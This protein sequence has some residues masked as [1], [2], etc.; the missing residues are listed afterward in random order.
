MRNI[1]TADP[2]TTL[3]RRGVGALVK[4]AVKKVNLE[5]HAIPYYF[6]SLSIYCTLTVKRMA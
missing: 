6:Q 4:M 2:F 5:F 1:L 3:D